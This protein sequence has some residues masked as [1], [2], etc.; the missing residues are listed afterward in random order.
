MEHRD[1]AAA[2]AA[3]SQERRIRLVERLVAAGG[4][5]LAAGEIAAALDVAPSTLSFHLAALEQAGLIDARRRGRQ[6]IYAARP[7]GLRRLLRFA[8]AL[9]AGGDAEAGRRLDALFPDWP[10]AGGLVPAFDVLFLCR[11]N[12]ARSIMA[13][14]ILDA[15][16][17]GRFRAHS[18]GPQPAAAPL[19]P[20]VDLL[21]RHGHD[22]ARLRSKPWSEFAGGRMDFVITLCDMADGPPPPGF[23]GQPLAALW[24]LP[25]P[26]RFAGTAAE[27][28]ALLQEL[29]RGI[30]GRLD[31]FCRL[32]LAALDR[33]A[34]QA[35]LDE[36]GDLAAA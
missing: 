29:Y 28:Q 4:S 7:A 35:W 19:P 23:A 13:E 16:G 3:L 10:V 17:R 21:A 36:I 20:V 6:L 34:A 30:R 33:A 18:A 14:A 32:P 27:R 9:C 8:A 15:V 1:A 2:F 5:G 26:T 22:V 24:L 31:R 25:D 11:H 12:S